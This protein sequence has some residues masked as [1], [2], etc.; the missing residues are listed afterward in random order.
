MF[1]GIITHLGTVAENSAQAGLHISAEPDFTHTLVAGAS[2]AC[3][4]CCLT[5]RAVAADATNTL[6]FDLSPETRATTTLGALPKGARVHLERALRHGDELGGH[7]ITGH[8]DGTARLEARTDFGSAIQLTCSAEAKFAPFL[9]EKG[10]LA[11]DGVSLTL[12]SPADA[13]SV[14]ATGRCSFSVMLIPHT[15]SLT[16]LGER[17]VSQ[18]LNLEIDLMARYLARSAAFP[19]LDDLAMLDDPLGTAFDDD[20]G[21]DDDGNNDCD[22]PNL[23]DPNDDPNLDEDEDDNDDDDD[24]N[25]D[26]THD[27]TL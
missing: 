21:G 9:A 20:D 8:I 17:E 12:N 19:T 22:D 27:N 18:I 15:L 25:N 13:A 5:V 2:V 14:A 4:G 3:M 26:E 6:A 11:L 23:D 24:D 1:T 10:S 16:T 7:I